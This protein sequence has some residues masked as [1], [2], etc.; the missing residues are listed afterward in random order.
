MAWR[1]V[2]AVEADL[3]TVD[4]ASVFVDLGC[5]DNLSAIYRFLPWQFA[6]ASR[7]LTASCG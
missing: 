7:F 6:T 4:R 5:L 2:E 1:L 3:N